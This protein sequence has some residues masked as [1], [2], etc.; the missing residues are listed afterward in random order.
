MTF[1][2][3][4]GLDGAGKTELVRAVSSM[5]AEDESVELV[6]TREPTR[7]TSGMQVRDTRLPRLRRLAAAWVD[8]G[9]HTTEVVKPALGRG[10]IVA[11][12]RYYLSTAAYQGTDQADAA[13]LHAEHAQ[14]FPRPDLWVYVATPLWLCHQR[15]GKRRGDDSPRLGV[16]AKVLA[17]YEYLLANEP[18]G[19][20]LIVPG[21]GDPLD[22]ASFVHSIIETIHADKQARAG[23]AKSLESNSC[24]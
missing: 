20:V 7:G 18:L 23:W 14:Y 19:R 21:N 5:F 22:T 6:R 4:E 13:R 9:F 11:C 2:A 16:L 24:N 10:A 8:R 1:V 3:F 15:L 12:D 17:H